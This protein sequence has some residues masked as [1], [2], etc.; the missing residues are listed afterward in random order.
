MAWGT[1]GLTYYT[2]GNYAKAVE[3]S[4]KAVAVKPDELWIQ[5]NLALAS[6]LTK[7]FAKAAAAFDA[8]MSLA[9]APQDL[10]HPIASLKEMVSRDQSLVSAREI[11]VKLE[12]AWRRLKN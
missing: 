6:V 8:V 3:A 1:L 5:V 12:D 7:D 4:E 10:L 11:L 2:M 9:A